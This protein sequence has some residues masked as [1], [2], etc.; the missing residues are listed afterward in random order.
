MTAI[1]HVIMLQVR[2]RD[3]VMEPY[4]GPVTHG[5]RWRWLCATVSDL[6]PDRGGLL[7]AACVFQQVSQRFACAA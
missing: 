4:T 5:L 7:R 1:S 6:E 3:K 2:D